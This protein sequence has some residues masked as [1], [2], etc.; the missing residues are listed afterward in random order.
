MTFRPIE[1]GSDAFQQECALRHRV[2]RVP[3]G[4]SL[5]EEDLSG[6]AGQQHFGI[7]DGAELVACVIAVT[8]APGEAKIRQMAVEPRHRGQNLGRRLMCELEA[9][10]AAGGVVRAFLHARAT[11][12]G[13]YQKL[14]YQTTGGEFIEVGIPHF[15][16][17]KRLT[18][19]A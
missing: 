13:F 15:K 12:V 19:A 7:F 5:D 10:L 16:M 1:F 2:L 14:G 11:A 6:E 8:V 17:D 4:R 9:H 3:L 18:S